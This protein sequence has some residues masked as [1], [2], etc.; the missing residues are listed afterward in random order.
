MGKALLKL[1]RVIRNVFSMASRC[2]Y[3]WV[4]TKHNV[5]R[6]NMIESR[7]IHDTD[8]IYYLDIAIT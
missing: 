5:N 3:I 2:R 1:H 4:Q 8:Y 6:L 7:P